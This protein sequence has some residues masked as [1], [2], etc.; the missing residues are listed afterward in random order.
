LARANKAAA[1]E[2]LVLACEAFEAMEMRAW[3][4]RAQALL[5]SS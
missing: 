5:R 2:K 1:S 4:E 3:L